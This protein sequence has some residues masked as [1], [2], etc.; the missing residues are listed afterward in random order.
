ML[1]KHTPVWVWD[2]YWWPAYV[3]VPK[4]NPT[5]DVILVQF[6]SGVTAPVKASDV[7][8]RVPQVEKTVLMPQISYSLP[9]RLNLPAGSI[10]SPGIYIVSH[11]DPTHATPHEIVIGT[12]MTLPRCQ[13]CSNVRFSWKCLPPQKIEENAFFNPE[14]IDLA[15][16]LRSAAVDVDKMTQASRQLIRRS[17]QFLA[18]WDS[19][20]RAFASNLALIS[21]S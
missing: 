17:K 21:N 14:P 6:E 9:E 13:L 7:R 12:E 5:S 3:V 19:A 2:S 10:A 8:L 1:K 15:A 11:L 20:R 16:H 4:L 18:T